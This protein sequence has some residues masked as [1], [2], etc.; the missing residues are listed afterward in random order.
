MSDIVVY[1]NDVLTV[2]LLLGILGLISVF[3]LKLYNILD[4]CDFYDLKL[5]IVSLAIGVICYL[6]I[7]IGILITIG[8]N[9]ESTYIEYSIYFW[10]ARI[11]IVMV[12]IFWFAEIIIYAAKSAVEPVSRMTKRRTERIKNFY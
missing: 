9:I 7:E 8:K 4:K 3:L 1:S 6:L 2:L 12:W 10:F 5:S 11:F